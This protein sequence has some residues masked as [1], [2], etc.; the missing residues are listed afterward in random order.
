MIIF[1]N[2]RETISSTGI[3]LAPTRRAVSLVAALT[4]VL[5]AVHAAAA[6]EGPF[7][8]REGRY[9]QAELKYRD[10]LPV[11][12][13]QGTPEEMGQQQAA[14]VADAAQA[15]LDYPKDI[16]RVFNRPDEVPAL[17]EKGLALVPQ[18]P[19]HHLAELEAFARHAR[20]DRKVL[21]GTNTMVDSYR[22]R[23][24]C[25]SLLVEPSRSATGGTLLAR[26]LDF[27]SN[28]VLEQRSLVTVF[29]PQ[30]KRAFVSIGF[31]GMI[32]CLS[33]MNDAGLALAVHEVFFSRDK[34]PMFNPKGVPYMLLFRRILEEC[35]TVAEAERLLAS[36]ER[37]TLYNLALADRQGVAVAEVTPR[38][39]VV[40]RAESGLCACTNEF[41]SEAL[42]TMFRFSLRQIVLM[43]S[44]RMASLGVAD[45]AR[46]MHQVSQGW[47]TM[48]TMVFEPGPLRIHLAM[49][50]CPSSALPLAPLEL[51]PLLTGK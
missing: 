28:G 11:L 8:F 42:A 49:G 34:A 19:P 22:G 7:R 14:L 18:I 26:N 48:Q 43:Q 17:L 40:R 35:R 4:L 21:L 15:V 20:I 38:T 23:F 25:S 5:L 29:R 13:V 6:A 39:I 10:G 41:R 31:P 30:G 46:K 37:T 44:H 2:R 9:G 50:K 24:G 51:G 45:L 16:A 47:L 33:G 3:P 1:L 12:T 36:V 27:Y 32:G